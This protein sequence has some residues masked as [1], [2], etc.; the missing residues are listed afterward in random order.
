[1]REWRI[2]L[3][4]TGWLASGGVALAASETLRLTCDQLQ[5]DQQLDLLQAD[6][7][8]AAYWGG[9][10]LT[11]RRIEYLRP[12]NRMTANGDVVVS[13]AGD[14][15]TGE[16]AEFD[17][18]TEKGEIT[19]PGIFLKKPNL[20]V[21]GTQMQRTS[22]VDYHVQDASFTTCNGDSPSWRIEADEMDITLEEYATARHA[23]FYAANIP[24][25]YFPYL[26][27]PVNAE[28]QTGLLLPLIGNSSKKGFTYTQ[29]FYWAISPSADATLAIGYQSKRGVGGGVDL[30]YLRPQ[31]SKG[32]LKGYA[33]YD[34]AEQR[35]QGY[36]NEAQRE[37][38][39]SALTLR[40]NITQVTYRNFFR[41]VSVESGEYNKQYLESTASLDWRGDNSFVGLGARAWRNLD[42]A[43]TDDPL[44]HLP[45]AS[46]RLVT[47]P[48]GSLP[49]AVGI[50]STATRFTR[51]TGDEGMRADV[52]PT[53][54]L[55]SSL[56]P[57]VTL[58]ADAGYQL[59][60]YLPKSPQGESSQG[61]GIATAG[62]E[63]T[64]PLEKIYDAEWSGWATHLRHTLLPRTGYRYVQDRQ[65]EQLPFYDWNDRTLGRQEATWSLANVVQG[66][67]TGSGGLREWRDLLSVRLSQGVLLDGS[68]RDLLAPADHGDRVG[69]LRLEL[70]ATPTKPL[71][72]WLDSRYNPNHAYSSSTA[73]AVEYRDV[74]DKDNKLNLG[75]YE[76]HGQYSYLEAKLATSLLRPVFAE[77]RGR[78]SADRHGFLESYYSLEYRHQCWGVTVSYHDRLD[79]QE[80]MVSFSLGGITSLG[81]LKV[82]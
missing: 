25:F 8:V 18:V 81:K 39:T 67:F 76:A 74:A 32:E 56:A 55:T 33:L 4:L 35:T 45:V 16:R 13:R 24:I 3:V 78:Y 43:V 80:V 52:T 12:A 48:L 82:F 58:A 30:R 15:F 26:T 65:Q 23:L 10:T 61:V 5:Y 31:Q 54:L 20:Y 28:R 6:G 7:N 14:R 62:A 44:Q 75:Y 70:L 29:P 71:S 22:P 19:A 40:S 21:H 72:I 57:G 77:Y 59:R 38:L 51:E 60:G 79:S 2:V 36:F 41:D 34:H 11:A 63:L 69:D 37:E 42:P 46:G 64:M 9:A 66:A 68:R 73:A 53:L 50:S 27:Y 49:M 17:L 1:M 47:S